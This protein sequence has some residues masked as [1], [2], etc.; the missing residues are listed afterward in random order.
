MAREVPLGQ[1]AGQLGLIESLLDLVVDESDES[2]VLL[3]QLLLE[4]AVVLLAHFFVLL[5][6]REKRKRL[7]G[8]FAPTRDS[9]G[10]PSLTLHILSQIIVICFRVNTGLSWPRRDPSAVPAVESIMQSGKHKVNA[11][12]LGET[13]LGLPEAGDKGPVGLAISVGEGVCLWWWR[14]SPASCLLR[15]ALLSSSRR[16]LAIS[17][18]VSV[19]ARNTDTGVG[20]TY[21]AAVSLQSGCEDG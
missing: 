5:L 4:D 1:V 2:V 9:L 10:W 14:V 15:L 16:L 17:M 12:P 3:A 21:D 7:Y 13:C 11:C 18:G 19:E 20:A 8:G 6:G